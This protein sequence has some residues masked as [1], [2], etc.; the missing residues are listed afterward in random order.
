MFVGIEVCIELYTEII[1]TLFDDFGKPQNPSIGITLLCRRSEMDS[2][3]IRTYCNADAWRRVNDGLWRRRGRATRPPYC[4]NSRLNSNECYKF[5]IM[6]L[7]IG[8]TVHIPAI[9]CLSF[10]TSTEMFCHKHIILVF[11][12]VFNCECLRESR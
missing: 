4:E 8:N 11:V 3:F 10:E 7:R 12:R 1:D 5:S 6:F 9:L 2:S